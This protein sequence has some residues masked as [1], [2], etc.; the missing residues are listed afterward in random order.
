MVTGIWAMFSGE[1]AMRCKS[2]G[3]SVLVFLVRGGRC[4]GEWGIGTK[5]PCACGQGQLGTE[6]GQLGTEHGSGLGSQE[7]GSGG[8]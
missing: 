5:R 6:Q 2:F 4:V 1:F 3:R 7:V 8:W